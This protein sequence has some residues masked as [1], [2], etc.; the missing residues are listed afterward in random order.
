MTTISTILQ[1]ITKPLAK[2]LDAG[3]ENASH[4]KYMQKAVD[5]AVQP[6]S[7]ST[8][9]N[10][11]LKLAVL[12]KHLPAIFG[13]WLSGYYWLSAMGSKT[14]PEERKLPL[15][16]NSVMCGVIGIAAGYAIDGPVN[17]LKNAFAN[18]ISTVLESQMSKEALKKIAEGF[19]SL[20]PLVVFTFTF[21]YLGPVIATPVAD[22]LAKFAYKKGW[23]KDPKAN[24]EK[25][26]TQP[27]SM[28]AA[29][30]NTPVAKA[31]D[32]DFKSFL[33][34]VGKQ[35]VKAFMA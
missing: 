4:N 30:L 35:N 16:I 5:W 25:E 29:S 31:A 33:T 32:S 9:T 34:T 14:I 15:A 7:S 2:A 20:V 19:Q 21:R 17:I 3:V 13:A 8:A 6:S 12:K 18:R 26:A 28:G 1:P 23:A 10:K 24:K 11:V 27:V 22:K